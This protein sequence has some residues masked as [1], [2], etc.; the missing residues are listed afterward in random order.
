MIQQ[1]VDVTT[2]ES[3]GVLLIGVVGDPHPEQMHVVRHQAV[4]GGDQI[5]ARECMQEHFAKS[6]VELGGEPAL[7]TSIDGHLPMD[8]GESTVGCGREAGKPVVP[9]RRQVRG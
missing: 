5:V 8:G 1:G 9:L 2:K 7:A 6:Q 3:R 4:D